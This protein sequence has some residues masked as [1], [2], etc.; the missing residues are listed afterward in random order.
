[1]TRRRILTTGA[2]LVLWAIPGCQ[3]EALA[4][5]YQPG[6]EITLQV[7]GGFAG[8]GYAVRLDGADGRLVGVSCTMICEFTPG[9]VLAI[10]TPEELQHLL[11][12]FRS[13]G[14]HD[15]DGMD[16]GTQCCDQFHYDLLYRDE[17][18]EASVRGSS[19]AFPEK[20]RD[21]LSSLAALVN[22]PRPLVVDFA[23][24]PAAWP[25][26]PLEIQIPGI[27]GDILSVRVAYGGGCKVHLVRG[28]AVGGFMESAPVQVR[29]VL[30]HEDHDD[31]CDAWLT[32]ELRF[33]LTPLKRAY[34]DAYGVGGGA[35][36][37]RVL[38]DDP[39]LASPLGAWMLEYGF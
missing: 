16:Y 10:L 7:S 19:E 29:V 22:G 32:R 13:A 23:G 35:T 25:R 37:L 9:E 27:E 28:V 3:E 38:L 36:S 15:L 4:P 8:V 14:I 20:L 12:L 17:A 6:T 2:L 11:G 31:P 24:D 5:D 1:M 30:S 26:D 39:R 33:D 34:Q 21:A 18:G